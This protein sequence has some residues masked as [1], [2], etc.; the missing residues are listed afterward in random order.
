[1]PKWFSHIRLQSSHQDLDR[2]R[3]ATLGST[4]HEHVRAL[5]LGHNLLNQRRGVLS[6][7]RLWGDDPVV[8]RIS[9]DRFL[10]SPSGVRSRIT[11]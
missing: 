9:F 7:A 1:M 2:Q 3:R 11:T 4:I 6:H 5:S 10:A 8:R